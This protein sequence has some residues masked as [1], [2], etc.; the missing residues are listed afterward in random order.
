MPFI[1]PL[2]LLFPAYG[3]LAGGEEQRKCQPARAEQTFVVQVRLPK[4]VEGYKP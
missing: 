3:S 4:Q 2:N 1:I